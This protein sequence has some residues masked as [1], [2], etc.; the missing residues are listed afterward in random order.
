[1]PLNLLNTV[2]RFVSSGARRHSLRR[3]RDDRVLGPG[4]R[5]ESWRSPRR[6][7]VGSGRSGCGPNPLLWAK[8]HRP[9]PVAPRARPKPTP[10]PFKP[11]TPDDCPACRATQP[12]LPPAS[13]PPKPYSQV[14]SPR[15]RKKWVATAGYGCP[16]PDCLYFGI[17]DDQVHALVGCGSHGRQE[18]IPDLKCQAC[19]T[20]FSVRYDTVLYRLTTPARR[21]GEVLSALAECLSV[22]AAVRV[23]GPANSRSEPGLR[24]LAY[25]P[26][27]YTNGYSRI[28]RSNIS[29][30]SVFLDSSL[31][32]WPAYPAH[33]REAE[34]ITSR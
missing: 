17:D 23:F 9:S 25:L 28:W 27:H 18:Y 34:A 31:V 11:R 14:K 29:K 22:G 15:G 24:V 8:W 3:L 26:P 7:S 20:K 6:F 10:R 4:P 33:E 30:V 2:P 12:G 5:L 19:Q 16:N 13:T 32:V 21:V 1:V